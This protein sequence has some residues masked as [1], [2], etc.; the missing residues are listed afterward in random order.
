[1]YLS[2]TRFQKGLCHLAFPP[3]MR[4]NSSPSRPCHLLALSVF[5]VCHW[6]IAL[7][8]CVSPVALKHPKCVTCHLY[9]PFAQSVHA[10]FYFWFYCY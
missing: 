4:E 5:S 7:S 1:M 10:H 2:P 8:I 9:I 3:A 6:L